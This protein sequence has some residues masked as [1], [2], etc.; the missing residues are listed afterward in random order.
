MKIK[1]APD[2]LQKQSLHV[3]PV[4]S[5]EGPNSSPFICT[6]SLFL[7]HKSLTQPDIIGPQQVISKSTLLYCFNGCNM[8]SEQRI[9]DTKCVSM[10]RSHSSGSKKWLG[11]S[12][13]KYVLSL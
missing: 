7:K 13:H 11:A 12:S 2:G 6:K 4:E 5:E 1:K 10:P 3:L 9:S 8:I